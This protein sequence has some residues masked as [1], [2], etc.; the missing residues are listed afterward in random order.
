MSLDAM[1]FMHRLLQHVLP[2]G[3]MKIRYYGF[4]SPGASVTIGKIATLIEQAC[5]IASKK[6][7]ISKNENKKS[8]P[9]SPDCS[10]RLIFKCFAPPMKRKYLID[11][12]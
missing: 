5:R 12:G 10:G 9:C 3:F 4:M 11:S 7:T 8:K 2:C 6:I 1:E